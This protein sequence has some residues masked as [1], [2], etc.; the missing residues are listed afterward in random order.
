[1]ISH[2]GVSNRFQL[3]LAGSRYITDVVKTISRPS[4]STYIE[5]LTFAAG[6]YDNLRLLN[7]AFARGHAALFKLLLR[8][9]GAH[10]FAGQ[11][12][13]EAVWGGRE[14][15]VRLLAELGLTLDRL[16]VDYRMLFEAVF[17]ENKAAIR[18]LMK[19]GVSINARDC[20]GQ[21]AL[22]KAAREGCKAVVQLLL[23]IGADV[24]A[25]NARGRTALH[26]ASDEEVVQLLLDKGADVRAKDNDGFPP[27]CTVHI[28]RAMRNN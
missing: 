21:T 20:Y 19:G 9:P 15:M 7:I 18:L 14:K 2:L 13:C 6:T 16:G 28:L 5:D 10:A 25:K 11:I 1:M 17:T 22:H 23:E 24:N 27:L 4:I 8:R 3:K 26:I 12:M